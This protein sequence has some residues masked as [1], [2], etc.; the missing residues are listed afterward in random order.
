MSGRISNQPNV[1]NLETKKANNNTRTTRD[2]TQKQTTLQNNYKQKDDGNN[3]NLKEKYN[4]LEHKFDSSSEDWVDLLSLNPSTFLN[5][6]PLPT[7]FEQVASL[8]DFFTKS[9]QKKAVPKGKE[10]PKPIGWES[11]WVPYVESKHQK[12]RRQ[13]FSNDSIFYSRRMNEGNR[14][15]RMYQSNLQIENSQAKEKKTD[16]SGSIYK[17]PKKNVYP[18]KFVKTRSNTEPRKRTQNGF[19]LAEILDLKDD[20]DDNF[21]NNNYSHYNNYHHNDTI[22]RNKERPIENFESKMKQIYSKKQLSAIRILR[23]GSRSSMNLKELV[24]YDYEGISNNS[25]HINNS[26]SNDEDNDSSKI[27][28]DQLLKL[29]ALLGNKYNGLGKNIENLRRNELRGKNTQK[30]RLSKPSHLTVSSNTRSISSQLEG[31]AN[32]HFT[33]GRKGGRRLRRKNAPHKFKRKLTYSSHQLQSSILKLAKAKH[34]RIAVETF[35]KLLFYMGEPKSIKKFEKRNKRFRSK[36]PVRELAQVEAIKSILEI[37]INNVELRDEIYVQICKQTTNNPNPNSN[38]KAWGAM[39]LAAQTFPPSKMLAGY[40]A[41]LYNYYLENSKDHL[42][43][44]AQYCKEKVSLTSEKSSGFMLPSD[45]MITRIFAVPFDPTVFSV[46]LE[47]CMEVQKRWYPNEIIPHVLTFLIHKIK[48][49][50]DFLKEG[51]FRIPGN[52]KKINE[53]KEL[54]DS[55]VY[56]IDDPEIDNAFCYASTLKSWLRDLKEPLVPFSFVNSILRCSTEEQM[57]EIIQKI[58]Q[59]Q[60]YTLAYLVHFVKEMMD[61]EIVK[62]TKMDKQSLVLMFAPNIVRTKEQSLT[63]VVQINAKRNLFLTS[64]LNKWEIGD[65]INKI[66]FSLKKSEK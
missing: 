61:P 5:D 40:L 13:S 66:S 45:R 37:G 19:N 21:N 33:Q 48:N 43:Q 57:L 36:K 31:Y 4:F 47:H 10:I 22:L 28:N 26:D 3:N 60:K 39:C 24:N 44:F 64:L 6:T 14:T 54:L 41:I 18:K 32:E 58:P 55:G 46:T 63:I 29:Q 65:I 1:V 38:L 17:A 7:K 56:D 52:A 2:Q 16:F 34:N 15:N 30:T 8:E 27:I 53:L 9:D 51:L 11:G 20:D 62:N 23:T 25:S 49:S 35:K 59:L 50:K 42:I 12:M